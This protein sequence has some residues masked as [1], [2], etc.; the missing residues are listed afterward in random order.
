MIMTPRKKNRKHTVIMHRARVERVWFHR[1]IV[2]VMVETV[3]PEALGR[4]HGVKIQMDDLK[5]ADGSALS[6]EDDGAGQV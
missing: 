6:A 4:R 3:T 1:T 2:L 5:K